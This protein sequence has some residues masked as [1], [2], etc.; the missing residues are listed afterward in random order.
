[1]P[2]PPIQIEGLSKR[3]SKDVLAVDR[4]D[5]TVEEGQIFG[6]L[7]PNGAG[8]TT[9]LRMLVGLV[10]PTA[11]GSRLFGDVVKP[12]ARAL[13]RVGTLVESPG[14][15]PH[16][17]GLKNLELFWRAGGQ[18]IDEADLD[19]ALEVADLGRAINRKVKTYSHGMKQRLGI[20]QALLGKPDLLIL[21]EPTTGLDPQQMREMR[22]LIH[23]I[24]NRGATVLLSSHL[25]GE[26][27][28]VCSHAAIVNKGHV[29]ATGTVAE[30]IGRATTI[31]IEVDDVARARTVL[32]KIPGVRAVNEEGTG[33]SIDLE[34]IDRKEI[35]A[36]LVRGGVGVETVM[37][38]HRLEDAFLSMLEDGA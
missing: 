25:L 16:L 29:V 21:D 26:V 27:E 32:S 20:A 10:R 13:R 28:Q 30:L 34:E 6:L 1:M 19:G 7:G 4:L 36:K 23:S 35:V 9:T 8:K 5:L 12:G 37:S 31:Y 14:F 33:L 2:A 24:A 22:L 18:H 38:R 15:V 17:S 11:G 3:F